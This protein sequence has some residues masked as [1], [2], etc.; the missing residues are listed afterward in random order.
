[1]AEEE[2]PFRVIYD[3]RSNF[4]TCAIQQEIPF[5]FN[6][7]GLASTTHGFINRVPARFLVPQN[8]QDYIFE[9]SKHHIVNI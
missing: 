6:L 2:I 5:Y 1:M 7:S 9:R 4:K 8:S 3:E